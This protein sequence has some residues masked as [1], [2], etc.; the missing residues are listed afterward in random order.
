MFKSEENPTF[1]EQ[2]SI[3][4]LVSFFS[5]QLKTNDA[6]HVFTEVKQFVSVSVE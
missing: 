2:F 5:I 3:V 6:V 4:D 1:N